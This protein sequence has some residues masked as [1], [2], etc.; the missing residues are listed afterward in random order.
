ML[1]EIITRPAAAANCDGEGE[2]TELIVGCRAVFV[3]AANTTSE[4]CDGKGGKK[5]AD[6]GVGREIVAER[7]L[8]LDRASALLTAYTL[9]VV[10]VVTVLEVAV[11]RVSL[12]T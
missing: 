12:S 10:V 7:A 4:V 8:K 11:L 1:L 5:V 6:N 3:G 9:T 2:A